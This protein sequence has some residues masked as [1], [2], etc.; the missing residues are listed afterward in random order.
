MFFRNSIYAIA[1]SLPV[2]AGNAAAQTVSIGTN[3]QGS[4]AYAVGAAI[5]KVAIEKGDVQ[6]R[7]VPQGGPNVVV[8]LVNAGEL[9]FSIA[10]SNTSNSAIEGTG[11]F[12][13]ANPDL[14]VAAVRLDLYSG[15][16]VRADS[17]IKTLEDLKGKRVA[18]DFIKQ[19]TVH[20]N[21][22]A[23]LA[24]VG[25]SFEDVVRVP[26]TDGVSGV[27]D[28]ETGNVDSTFFSLNSGRTLQ[29]DAALGGTRVL[30]IADT[31][32]A[33]KQLAESRAGAWVTVLQPDP[34]F[35]GIAEAT[36]VYTA[37]F[38]LLTSKNVS[39]E[40]V[41]DVVKAI[42]E[43]KPALEASAGAFSSFD[44]AQMKRDIGL[45]FHPGALK[46]YA[47]TGN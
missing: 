9:E 32:Q 22:G 7:V 31:E 35:P 13:R 27:E 2:I 23:V 29:A 3:P 47:E 10:D 6:M 21:A 24:T 34:S 15:F 11:E 42:Y 28:F 4:L 14:R 40:T 33:A 26:V 46:F 18:S 45:P 25:L 12:R 36:P 16:M 41:H 37:A 19:A 44:P 38:V 30:P 20:E 43:N 5:S 39:D 17:D 1:L 8:P